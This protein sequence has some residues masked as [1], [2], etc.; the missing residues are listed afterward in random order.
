MKEH[1]TKKIAY[2]S[3]ID[4]GWIKQRPQFIAECLAEKYVVDYF[5][6]P[7]A[8][9][10]EYRNVN[11]NLRLDFIPLIKLP[12]SGRV[13]IIK[14]AQVLINTYKI[15][16]RGYDIIWV[17][18][19][20]V[21]SRVD[22]ISMEVS[23]IYDCMDDMIESHTIP[24]YKSML[25]S[26]ECQLLEKS[27]CVFV[28]SDSLRSKMLHRGCD[29]R[30]LSVVYNATNISSLLRNIDKPIY[31]KDENKFVITYF[32]TISRWID[33]DLLYAIL[34]DVEL[35]YVHIRL[36][37]PIDIELK[38]HPRLE[39]V[40]PVSHDKLA[41]YTAGT[42]L[43]ILPFILNDITLSVDPVKLYEYIAFQRNIAAVYYAELDRYAEFVNF[44]KNYHDLKNMISQMNSVGSLTY[45][46]SRAEEFVMENTWHERCE[47]IINEIEKFNL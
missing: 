47:Q 43:F 26:Y 4:W 10:T 14:K 30:K 19:P 46:L 41:S 5:Y 36:I 37:G 9:N 21:L 15:R 24:K 35:N 2:I 1:I 23:I 22:V 29:D 3:H 20:E 6:F 40:A 42:D 28:S 39:Y 44:Y 17:C 16:A 34:S 18:S 31:K 11:N 38:K 45:E 7:N 33:T 27:S 25:L 32:G 13:S 8:E 12:F